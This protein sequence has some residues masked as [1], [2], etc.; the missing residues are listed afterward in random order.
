[1]GG[2]GNGPARVTTTIIVNERTRNNA[3]PGT[4]AFSAAKASLTASMAR[5][6]HAVDR[7]P[8][9]NSQVVP[10]RPMNPTTVA[11]DTA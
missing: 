8:P 4:A 3:P 10:A 7:T 11:T 9:S 5:V 6:T 2:I 1:M